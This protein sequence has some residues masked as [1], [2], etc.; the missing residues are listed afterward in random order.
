MK[1]AVIYPGAQM[2]QYVET[3]EPVAAAG[4]VLVSIRAV[5][6]KN[7]DKSK[8]SGSHYSSGE[9]LNGIVIG[10][11]GTGLLE[12]G[13]RVYGIGVG[14]T[15]AEKALFRSDLL[16]PVPDGL[17][18]AVSAALPNA[19]MGSA[20]ALRFRAAMQPGETVL[21]NGATGFTGRIAVQLAREYGAGRIIVTGRN[22]E[23]LNSLIALGAD[24]VVPLRGD[25]QFF[26]AKLKSIH[27][28]TPINVII[29][30]LWGRS[31]ET[32]LSVLQGIGN[33]TPKTRFVSVGAMGGG[34]I[35]LSSELLRGTDLQ[36]SGSGLGSWS[37]QEIGILFKTI[38]PDAFQM[39]LDGRLKVST[40]SIAA[41][42]IGKAWETALKD[43]AR[44]VA[45]I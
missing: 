27:T 45:V 41:D 33:F 15:I 42:E 25:E 13:Q 7:L 11:D 2:P 43:G 3:E 16:V 35:S 34:S 10:S 23:S 29:D 6:I 4:E 37:M 18:D 44:L 1:T 39:A 21:I 20:M 22:E 12:N 24:E 38:L 31:A 28:A 14:G 19:V 8:A 26:A 5:S 40:V 32:I 9:N 30:Y 36:L 17:E